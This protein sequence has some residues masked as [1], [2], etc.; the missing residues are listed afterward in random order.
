MLIT[1]P[2]TMVILCLANILHG[3]GGVGG[4]DVLP[5]L[6]IF[7]YSGEKTVRCP[8][9]FATC[10][11]FLM[12]C[13]LV[14]WSVRCQFKVKL[15]RRFHT[16]VCL[17]S[18]Q[19]RNWSIYTSWR[20]SHRF[21][22][23]YRSRENSFWKLR[24]LSFRLD[25]LDGHSPPPPPP[26]FFLSTDIPTQ[27]FTSMNC[28]DGEGCVCVVG[29]RHSKY[30][31]KRGLYRPKGVVFWEGLQMWISNPNFN[32]YTIFEQSTSLQAL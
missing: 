22:Y 15:Q 5:G 25:C 2:G 1:L 31:G 17:H 23:E 24:K 8:N 32:G 10:C 20:Q 30:I 14:S 3:G 26:P 18:A 16:E 11:S 7:K 27:A 6:G 13:Q 4:G 12:I 19:L 21:R 28:R 9:Y 29:D